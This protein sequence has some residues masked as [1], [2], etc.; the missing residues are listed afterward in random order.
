MKYHGVAIAIAVW[1]WELVDGADFRLDLE[2]LLLCGFFFLTGLRSVAVL[3]CGVVFS[4]MLVW[5]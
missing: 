5:G 2:F 4:G 3:L 1:L